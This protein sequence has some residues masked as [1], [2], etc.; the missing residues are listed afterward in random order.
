MHAG[1]DLKNSDT[2]LV[3]AAFGF[4]CS[5]SCNKCC[6]RRCCTTLSEGVADV[7]LQ[8]EFAAAVAADVINDPGPGGVR[9][10]RP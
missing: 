6:G 7:L 5:A 9:A 2:V 8:I 4:C 3:G 1:P 10:R